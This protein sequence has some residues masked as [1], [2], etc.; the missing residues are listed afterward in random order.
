MVRDIANIETDSHIK[1]FIR[2]LK[3][4]FLPG[5]GWHNRPL[6]EVLGLLGVLYTYNIPVQK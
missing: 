3:M 6:L 5:G 2:R 1:P 4:N